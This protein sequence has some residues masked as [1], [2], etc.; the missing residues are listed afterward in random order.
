MELRTRNG[1][2]LI[3]GVALLFAAIGGAGTYLLLRQKPAAAP[4]PV[5]APY[6]A[7]STPT[8]EP[9]GVL[10]EPASPSA[11]PTPPAPATPVSKWD[12]RDGRFFSKIESLKPADGRWIAGVDYAQFLM[13]AEAAA[14]AEAAGEESPPPN[15]YFIVNESE[16][17]RTWPIAADVTV[18]VATWPEHFDA[19]GYPVD[20]AAWRAMYAGTDDS[21]PRA[22]E[23]WYW[24][25]L[26][27][28][29][30]TAIDEQYL[31]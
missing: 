13:G 30:I 22:N 20:F 15:D 11:V 12:A 29:V 7:V 2:L 3:A 10:T 31:P 16:K 4:V 1:I 23:V 21:F 24:I 6:G 5:P 26:S 19:S 27:D 28:G 14:A 9:S 8:P 18:T 17:V 25:T